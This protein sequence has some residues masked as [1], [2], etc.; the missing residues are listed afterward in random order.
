M[1][2]AMSVVVVVVGVSS[3]EEE[4]LDERTGSEVAPPRPVCDDGAAAVAVDADAAGAGFANAAA[5]NAGPCSTSTGSVAAAA[6]AD[7][8]ADAASAGCVCSTCGG[9]RSAC[10][11]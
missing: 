10:V 6:A 4:G 1:V 5:P 11:C 7:A 3:A 8:D 2:G 9:C